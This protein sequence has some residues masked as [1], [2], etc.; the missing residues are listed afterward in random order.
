MCCS[1]MQVPAVFNGLISYKNGM[2]GAIA[3]QVRRERGK[4]VRPWVPVL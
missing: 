1:S 3:T 2:K 4:E